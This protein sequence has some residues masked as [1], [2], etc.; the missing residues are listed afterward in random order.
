MG[1]SFKKAALIWCVV[2]IFI[3]LSLPTC[4]A[5]DDVGFVIP[6]KT[7]GFVIGLGRKLSLLDWDSGEVSQTLHEVQKKGIKNR[8]N[9]AKCDP[10]GRL[11]AG[12]THT[13]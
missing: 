3:L 12:N 1:Q 2:I 9:D 11:W 5:D 4:V 7:G 6:R 10:S 8:F 13:Y